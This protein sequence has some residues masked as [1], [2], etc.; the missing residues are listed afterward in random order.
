MNSP[1]PTVGASGAIA[2]VLGAYANLYPHARVYTLLFWGFFSRVV[3]MP[4]IGVLGFWFILQ[5][6][7]A[8]ATP[9]GMGGVAYGAHIGGFVA[10]YVLVRLFC[11]PAYRRFKR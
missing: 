11:K 2:G 10:G 8:A 9:R 7:S 1:V 6:L 5:L 3:L 4:A